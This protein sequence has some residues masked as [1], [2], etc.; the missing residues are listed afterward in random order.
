MSTHFLSQLAPFSELDE[1]ELSILASY[2]RRRDVGPL[3]VLFTQG[4]VDDRLFVVVQGKLSVWKPLSR[5]REEWM[6]DLGPGAVVGH[7]SLVDGLPRSATVR[8][9]EKP[10]ILVELRREDFESLYRQGS[11]IA[12]KMLE[13]LTS[14]LVSRLRRVTERFASLSPKERSEPRRLVEGGQDLFG[15]PE[16]DPRSSEAWLADLDALIAAGPGA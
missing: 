3:E 6:A 13:A 12:F 14:D 5:G 4:Q 7:M 10:A 8:A 1:N 15:H 16:V 9:Q 2:L 11:P